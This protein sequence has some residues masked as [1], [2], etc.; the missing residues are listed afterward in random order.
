MLNR[1]IMD[2]FL[3]EHLFGNLRHELNL[4]A[5]LRHDFNRP[6]VTDMC[7]TVGASCRDQL[8]R[9]INVTFVEKRSGQTGLC[10]N[11]HLTRANPI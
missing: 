10:A 1:R 3:N 7:P 6:T 4:V 9:Q 2:E 11:C 8:P 5:A